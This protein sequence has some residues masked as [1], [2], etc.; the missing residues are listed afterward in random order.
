M[1]L[2]KL[3][4]GVNWLEVYVTM[5]LSPSA[6]RRGKKIFVITDKAFPL[7]FLLIKD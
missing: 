5:N 7:L 6:I 1:H 4:N 3:N 2:K